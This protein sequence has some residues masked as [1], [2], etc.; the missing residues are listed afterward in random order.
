MP[1][2]LLSTAAAAR[3]GCS[4]QMPLPSCSVA[5]E[6]LKRNTHFVLNLNP[7]RHPKPFKR[8]AP[9]AP[10][11]PRIASHCH[12]LHRHKESTPA[13]PHNDITPPFTHITHSPTSSHATH[14]TCCWH[15]CPAM[16][17]TCHQEEGAAAASAP[18]HHLLQ[19]W[20]CLSQSR[21]PA[22]RCSSPSASAS[23]PRWRSVSRLRLVLLTW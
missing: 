19:L 1:H 6:Q 21:S 16:T 14:P 17:S 15:L 4:C 23:R 9:P 18:R 10:N 11:N 3:D 2:Q 8:M 12:L 7:A 20:A 22:A 5:P 13:S